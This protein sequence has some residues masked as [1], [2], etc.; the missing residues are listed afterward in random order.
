MLPVSLVCC[1]L[2]C[3]LLKICI[4][5]HL[6][7]VPP[8]DIYLNRINDNALPSRNYRRYYNYNFK[9]CGDEPV[10]GVNLGGWLV[11][12]PYITPSIFE[13]FRVSGVCD[14]GI[15][16]D[17]YHLCSNLGPH[18]AHQ[19]LINHWE[20]F[21]TENDFTKIKQLGFNLVR[22]PVGY[23]AFNKLADDPY[24]TGLQEI[25][26]D[27]AIEW[28]RRHGLKVW[29][30]IHGAAGSQNGF[31]NSG[32]RDQINFLDESNIKVTVK[33]IKHVLNKYS[34][35]EYLDT[36]IGIELLNEPLGPF[37]DINLFKKKYIL[38]LHDYLRNE[39]KNKKQT[40][41]IHDAFLPNDVWNGFLEFPPFEGV[42][43]D[44]HHYQVFS[45]SELQSK[46][47]EKLQTVCQWGQQHKTD[48][49]WNI[50]G[51]FSA[52]LTDCTKWLNGVGVGARMDGSFWKNGQES[53]YIDTCKFNDDILTWSMDRRQKTRHYIETQFDV[54]EQTGG[55]IFWCYKTERS[56]EWDASKLAAYG[57]LPQPLTDRKY[58]KVCK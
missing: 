57:M 35:P 11:L 38:P 24:L 47:D 7:E 14:D 26:L 54:F 8:S 15:P 50:V 9:S 45:N 42:L 30:D 27:K 40:I 1:I 46:F 4:G 56:I 28:S 51:E 43:I 33:A 55:W 48:T 23:W 29:I 31:D 18:Q 19:L 10:R 41:V 5:A 13:K 16:V 12:E 37:I 34:K 22:I 25:Y 44:H 17:E 39:L 21:Y 2:S 58:S 20:T 49:H 6:Y 52:A 53:H 36:V 3:L 32:L